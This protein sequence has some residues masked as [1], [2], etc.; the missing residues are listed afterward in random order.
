MN[1]AEKD[2]YKVIEKFF[3][4]IAQP[5]AKSHQESI[6]SPHLLKEYW[7]LGTA[8]SCPS[9]FGPYCTESD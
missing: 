9:L 1:E 7:P 8:L 3:I 2:L 4:L 6:H 5:G